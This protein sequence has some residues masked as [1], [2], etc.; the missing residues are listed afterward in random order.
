MDQ[1]ME[2]HYQ[3]SD[4]GEG[5]LRIYSSDFLFLCCL[6]MQRS[7]VERHR[8]NQMTALHIGNQNPI[9]KALVK[10]LYQFASR[11]YVT[12]QTNSYWAYLIH[13]A[14]QPHN[15]GIQFQPFARL[16]RD[17][18]PAQI[19]QQLKSSE[20]LRDYSFFSH[21]NQASHSKLIF[22]NTQV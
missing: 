13:V 19:K 10:S 7:S 1:N 22:I 17:L 11:A 8:K 20:E 18:I 21:K 14:L 6:M 5:G 3:I 4:V 9:L 2:Q 16:T 15:K 12:P